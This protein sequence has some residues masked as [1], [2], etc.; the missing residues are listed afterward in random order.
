MSGGSSCRRRGSTW[1]QTD[2]ILH[3][4]LLEAWPDHCLGSLLLTPRPD[5]L[6][7]G[8]L[9]HSPAFSLIDR[10]LDSAILVSCRRCRQGVGL[11]DVSHRLATS[12]VVWQ[13]R[14]RARRTSG[15]GVEAP[16]QDG[17]EA[18]PLSC[19]KH[20]RS[21]KVVWDFQVDDSDLE[22]PSSLRNQSRSMWPS[23][24]RPSASSKV[25]S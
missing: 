3:H 23:Q 22:R 2:L 12:R 1:P 17:A 10:L 21:R 8:R 16:G 14:R 4:H 9:P 18:E 5:P 25:A 24:I 19:W 15:E 13:N 20:L 6:S 11:G 7:V